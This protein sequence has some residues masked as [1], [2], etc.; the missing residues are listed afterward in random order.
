MHALRSFPGVSLLIV[1]SVATITPGL[2]PDVA[3]AQQRHADERVSFDIPSMPLDAALAQYF[4]TTGVQL[5]YDATLTTGRRSTVVR[6]DQAPREALRKLL[7]GTGLIA[8][9]SKAN[10]AIITTRGAPIDGFPVPLGRVIVRERIAGIRL[11]RVSRMAYYDALEDDLKAYLR[12][13]RRIDRRA[14]AVAIEVRIDADGR[15]AKI[16]IER[17]TGDTGTDRMLT[18]I[19]EN[20]WV[21]KPPDGLVQPLLLALQAKRR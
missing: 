3:V 6:G 4:R 19:L 17:G 21:S 9:Y 20:A 12:R 15:I 14:F 2:S 11:S 1:T 5:L 18:D 16:R 10:A 8:R 7:S 13:D